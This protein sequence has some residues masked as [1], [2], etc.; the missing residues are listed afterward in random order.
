MKYYVGLYPSGRV[1]VFRSAERITKEAFPLY[2]KVVGPFKSL[3]DATRHAE[4]MEVNPKHAPKE[5]EEEEER[6]EAEKFRRDQLSYPTLRRIRRRLEDEREERIKK[7]PGAEWHKKERIKAINEST[8]ARTSLNASFYNGKAVAHGESVQ[9]SELGENPRKNPDYDW[10]LESYTSIKRELQK[11]DDIE[12][13]RELTAIEK[14]RQHRLT[15]KLYEAGDNLDEEKRRDPEVGRIKKNPFAETLMIAGAN[16]FQS[17][18]QRR[19]FFAMESRGELRPGTSRR[20]A[21][22]TRGRLPERVRKNPERIYENALA[23]EAEKGKDS[24]WPGEKF[25]HDFKKGAIIEGMPDG[26]IRIKH[27]KGK[28][29]WKKFDY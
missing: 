14:S 10:H 29:L 24:L 20:W 5:R 27:R 13:N 9:A 1:K 17:K 15:G 25:R 3:W 12:R 2:K 28:R 19:K 11:L 18:A 7:N 4:T 8:N 21:H 6:E 26:S 22:E 23:I 16:P